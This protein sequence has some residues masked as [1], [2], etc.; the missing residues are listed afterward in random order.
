MLSQN[1]SYDFIFF[2]KYSEII[3]TQNSLRSVSGALQVTNVTKCGSLI[4][5]KNVTIYEAL[6][7]PHANINS[8][9]K[10]FA[11]ILVILLANN[12]IIYR[13]TNMLVWA[14]LHYFPP[15][16]IYPLRLGIR[17]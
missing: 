11:A 17:V 16:E 14:H 9:E 4:C 3:N 8:I 12:A 7:L 2:I 1:M 6:R 15:L 5:D 13:N 10:T